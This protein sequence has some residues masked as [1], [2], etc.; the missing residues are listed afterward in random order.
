MNMKQRPI[1]ASRIF[2]TPNDMNYVSKWEV[3]VVKADR[4]P[5]AEFHSID[6]HQFVASYY[7]E[8]LLTRNREYGLDLWGDVQEWTINAE[9][10][11]GITCW[12][13]S[14]ASEGTA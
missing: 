14:I 2:E 8:T 13:E 3:R 11:V 5:A 12:L 1:L 9:D 7:L 10:M 4:T 6:T